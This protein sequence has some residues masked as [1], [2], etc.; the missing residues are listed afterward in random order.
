MVLKGINASD[1]VGLG[2]AV[3]VREESLDYSDVPYSGKEAE[4]TRLQNAI[5]EFN[6]RTTAMAD[7]IR[8]Q[9]GPKEIGRAHV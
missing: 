8:E 9:T 5:D 2:R 7:R 3:C 4:K 6:Q 1:G